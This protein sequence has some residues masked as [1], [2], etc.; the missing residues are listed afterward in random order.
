[1][2]YQRNDTPEPIAGYITDS[3]HW[4][5]LAKRIGGDIYAD[6]VGR[7]WHKPADGELRRID[8]EGR[9]LPSTSAMPPAVVAMLE[10][11]ALA[12]GF[13]EFTYREGIGPR[14]RAA[15]GVGGPWNPLESEEDA[16]ALRAATGITLGHIW[17]SG[18]DPIGMNAGIT[19]GSVLHTW[20]SY[21]TDDD[22]ADLAEAG[23]IATVNAAAWLADNPLTTNPRAT[24]G[25][26]MLTTKEFIAAAQSG[27]L[28]KRVRVVV[29]NDCVDAYIEPETEDGNNENICRFDGEG[30][31]GALVAI[32]QG[33][34]INAD[35]A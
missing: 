13:I 31:E 35:R 5:A 1:M 27:T 17:K 3:D 28:D 4:N 34:G 26:P 22:V 29:D 24:I 19:R 2:T 7:L 15:N 8:R 16:V 33:F 12:A 25:E 10:R 9:P 32:L 6:E 11:A 30:P 20:G 23:R 21:L 18:P 14:A